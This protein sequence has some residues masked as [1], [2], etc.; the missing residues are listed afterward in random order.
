[1]DEKSNK[2]EVLQAIPSMYYMD[3]RKINEELKD[4]SDVM[5]AAVKRNPN[6]FEFASPRL[7]DDKKLAIMAVSGKGMGFLLRFV[8]QRL[9][10]DYQVVMAAIRGD[11]F[12]LEYASE[13]LKDNDDVVKTALEYNG[14]TL[15]YASERI[16]SDKNMVLLAVSGGYDNGYGLEYASEELKK[17]KDVVIAAV[18]STG[19]VLEYASENLKRDKDVVKAAVCENYCSLKHADNSLL[20]DGVFMSELLKM[21]P[22]MGQF[23]AELYTTRINAGIQAVSEESQVKGTRKK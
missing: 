5:Y 8:S 16:K 20:F 13:K 1:M 11:G 3:I 23:A 15:K 18:S 4:D 7:R 14:R 6:A 12:A 22:N 2:D 10:D 9:R 17:D 19:G 21:C